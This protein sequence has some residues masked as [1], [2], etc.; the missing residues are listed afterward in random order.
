MQQEETKDAIR[1]SIWDYGGQM[2]FY[3][4][5]HLFLTQYGV[6]LIVFN[7]QKLLDSVDESTE[8]LLFWLNSIKLH[9]PNAP[10]LL[11]GT[12][13][14]VL[15]EREDDIKKV[16]LILN[17]LAAEFDQVCYFE[18]L[19]YCPVSN[20]DKSGVRRTPYRY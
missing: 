17:E 13:L 12:F 7:M 19:V 20:K 16:S 5:H 15:D 9:A 4:L 6:Y 14:D 10:V 3:T 2:V 8:Y 11:V 1:M 18:H